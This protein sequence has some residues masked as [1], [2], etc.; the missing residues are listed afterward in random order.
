M[1]QKKKLRILMLNYEFPPLGGGGG[2][3]AYKLAKGFVKLGH[4]V[5]YV[6]TWFKG[7]KKEEN[8][9]GI[10]V[11]RVKVLGRKELPTATMLSMITYPLS[12]YFKCRKLCKKNRYDL[13]NTHF[14]IPSGPVGV[15]I[16]KEF[17]IKNILSL[18][19]GDIY[20][21]SKTN[22]PHKKLY[23]RIVVNWV[24]KNSNFLVAQSSNTKENTKKYY[25]VD[26]E[27]N[28]IPLAYE[29][30]KFKKI[31]REKLGLDKNK[32]YIISVGRLIPRKDYATLIR[33]LALSDKNI[34]SLIIGNGPE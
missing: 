6:T 19:G 9:D 29:P 3:A 2:V 26:K 27:I 34:E 12:A 14:A 33:A 17:K 22:S 4:E 8:V 13:I 5:D 31:S 7:F 32:K 15:W 20:D 30:F 18:H 11:Y 23:F 1:V 10:N 21:P 16:S 25:R 28:V 24:L